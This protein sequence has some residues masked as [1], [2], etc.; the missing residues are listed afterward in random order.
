MLDVTIGVN[1]TLELSCSALG[2]PPPQLT[3]SITPEANLLISQLPSNSTQPAMSDLTIDVGALKTIGQYAVTCSAETT[4]G[5]AESF[6][7]STTINFNVGVLFEGITLSVSTTSGIDGVVIVRDV[8]P[9][10]LILTCS[11]QST[12]QPEIRWLQNGEPVSENPQVGFFGT[13]AL[14]ILDVP[15]LALL[16][17]TVSFQCIATLNFS[18]EVFEQTANASVVVESFLQD[19]FISPN[20][21][22]FN[23][24]QPLGE[25]EQI[26]V[27][28]CT[29]GA[30][31]TP[32]VVWTLNGTPVNGTPIERIDQSLG[33]ESMLNINVNALVGTAVFTC[34]ASLESFSLTSSANA[35]VTANSK[36]TLPIHTHHFFSSSYFIIHAVHVNVP[37][38][39]LVK[40]SFYFLF[41]ETI[42]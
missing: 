11:V 22:T 13:T 37:F 30:G 41:A 18:G 39:H 26:V 34:M 38:S 16:P 20:E 7:D 2:D 32:T 24:I 33:Y 19:I 14:S 8:D 17:P 35:T 42:V 31:L 29:L 36:C 25:N 5:Q 1:S 12:F 15:T 10:L 40:T 9:I 4:D 28:R 21:S 6:T 27:L 3:W 23:L